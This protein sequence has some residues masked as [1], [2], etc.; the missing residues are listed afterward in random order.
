MKTKIIEQ[1]E[2]S[3]QNLRGDAASV[4]FAKEGERGFIL[5]LRLHL[6][7]CLSL[8]RLGLHRIRQ[9]VERAADRRPSFSPPPEQIWFPATSGQP[10]LSAPI[11]G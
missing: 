1:L 10:Q 5:R 11:R 9:A 2:L 3:F 4:G 7:P 8:A 6:R